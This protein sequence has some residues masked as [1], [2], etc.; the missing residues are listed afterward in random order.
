MTEFIFWRPYYIVS[1]NCILLKLNFIIKVIY[2]F[3]NDNV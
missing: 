2:K 3:Y 1:S